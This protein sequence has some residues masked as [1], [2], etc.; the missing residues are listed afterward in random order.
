M[1]TITTT[2]VL[3]GEI[4]HSPAGQAG[5]EGE[6][7]PGVAR[8]AGS[9]DAGVENVANAGGER[10]AQKEKIDQISRAHPADQL[11][12]EIPTGGETLPEII[13]LILYLSLCFLQYKDWSRYSTGFIFIYYDGKHSKF[14]LANS[15]VFQGFR[16]SS[17]GFYYVHHNSP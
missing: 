11:S 3:T 4:D 16:F 12:T 13:P 7:G 17:V 6:G 9:V 14:F 15:K 2:A 8:V 5:Q 1:E 10:Q